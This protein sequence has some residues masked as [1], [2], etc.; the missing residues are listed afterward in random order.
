MMDF[1]KSLL[2]KSTLTFSSYEIEDKFMEKYTYNFDGEEK[3][4]TYTV[5]PD[6]LSTGDNIIMKVDSTITID[7][8][9]NL[10]KYISIPAD[11]YKYYGFISYRSMG[12]SYETKIEPKD[13]IFEKNKL[14]YFEVQSNIKDADKIELILLVRGQKYTFILK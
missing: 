4:G 8:E 7:E 5:L 14:T 3:I 1:S 11:L 13:V 10:S 6:K 9:S 2:G 12:E